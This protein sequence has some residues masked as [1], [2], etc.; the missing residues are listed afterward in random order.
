MSEPCV[1]QIQITT[2]GPEVAAIAVSSPGPAV[3]FIHIYD[4]AVGA[5]SPLPPGYRLTFDPNHTKATL[6]LN[7]T[8]VAS[9]PLHAP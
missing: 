2:P 7:N 3:A 4:P 8:P 5:V 9:L 6:H 1:A